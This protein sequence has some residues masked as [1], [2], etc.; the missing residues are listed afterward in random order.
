MLKTGN[1]NYHPASDPLHF[2]HCFVFDPD[3]YC[4]LAESLAAVMKLCK[5]PGVFSCMPYILGI[6]LETKE[7][8]L[9]NTSSYDLTVLLTV[10]FLCRGIKSAFCLP[11][12]PLQPVN[13]QK[14]M[15]RAL[16][17]KACM[18]VTLMLNYHVY[19]VPSK[20][21]IIWGGGL[22]HLTNLVLLHIGSLTHKTFIALLVVH[23]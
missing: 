9:P 7:E 12:I 8:E 15:L 14:L 23:I 18:T 13:Q 11:L 6:W 2:F 17:N 16:W 20:S 22:G 19:S 4:F 5:V 21:R 1:K 10:S 3:Y